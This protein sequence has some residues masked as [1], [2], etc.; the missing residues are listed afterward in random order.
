M[1][2]WIYMNLA[3]LTARKLSK[4][5]LEGRGLRLRASLSS[6]LAGR[7]HFE[8]T[9]TRL[10]IMPC[11]PISQDAL[12]P[13]LPAGYMCLWLLRPPLPLYGAEAMGQAS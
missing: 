2:V 4:H 12:N 5:G 1:R 13:L 7:P 10:R 9:S 3:G 8:V 6:L 11:L